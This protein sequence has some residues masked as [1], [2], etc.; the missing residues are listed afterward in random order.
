MSTTD[1]PIVLSPDDATKLIRALAIRIDFA[2]WDRDA[3]DRI[4]ALH[5]RVERQGQSYCG[6]CV[7]VWPCDTQ[8]V[9][10]TWGAA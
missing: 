1:A 9:I 5:Y 4:I 10:E 8:R 2:S 7:V 6:G 3:L